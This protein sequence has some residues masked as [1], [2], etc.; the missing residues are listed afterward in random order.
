ML[1]KAIRAGNLDAVRRLVRGS[2]EGIAT[3]T[4]AT[5]ALLGQDNMVD[6]LVLEAGGNAFAALVDLVTEAVPSATVDRACVILA[7]HIRSDSKLDG[8]EGCGSCNTVESAFFDAVEKGLVRTVRAFV[9]QGLVRV[10]RPSSSGEWP[11]LRARTGDMVA[12]LVRLG[13]DPCLVGD[14]CNM[15]MGH[16]IYTGDTNLAHNLEEVVVWGRL[17]QLWT[18]S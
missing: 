18:P 15:L 1:E 10:D 7:A 11:I 9:Q 12:E 3:T 2:T 6:V 14:Q 5:A 13:T 8:D 4:L 16:A 17:C